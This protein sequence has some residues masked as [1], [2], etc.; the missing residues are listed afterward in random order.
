MQK[1]HKYFESK[2]NVKCTKNMVTLVN[3]KN[4]KCTKNMVTLVNKKNVKCTKTM[5]ILVTKK[6]GYFS[7][8]K[9]W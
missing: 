9:K 2:K 6:Y 3:N 1:Y 7:E 4:G 8:Q 5:V